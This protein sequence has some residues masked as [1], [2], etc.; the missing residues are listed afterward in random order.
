M[1]NAR[2]FYEVGSGRSNQEFEEKKY[3]SE[4]NLPEKKKTHSVLVLN[5]DQTI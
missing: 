2:V 4:P 1:R 3:E 5:S